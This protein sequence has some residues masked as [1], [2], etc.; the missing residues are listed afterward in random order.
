MID[1]TPDLETIL[2]KVQKLLNVEGRTP[3]EAAAYV[4]K[5]HAI[6]ADYDL[7][8]ESVHNLT[9]DKRTA[10]RKADSG[11][12]TVSGKPD[13]WKADILEAVAR[14][15][16]CKVIWAY[17]TEQTKSGNYR[18]VRVGNLI[19]FGHD[20][21]AAGYANSF[22][23]NEITRLAKAY[24]RPM[25]DQIKA[26][27]ARFGSSIHDA[28]KRY[29]DLWGRHPLKAELYF[30]RGAAETVKEALEEHARER[31]WAAVQNNPNALVVQKAA[32]VNDFLF[33]ER[34][35]GMSRA[36]YAARQDAW[37]Q[38]MGFDSFRAYEEHRSAEWR[39]EHEA[40]HPEKPETDAQRR[41]R[42]AR[43]ERAQE[44]ANRT[45]WNRIDRESRATD[46]DAVY[47]GREA[48]RTIRIRL[49][50]NPGDSKEGIG[51]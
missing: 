34:H 8:I 13:G 2:A 3:E 29:T 31:E 33:A 45:Y 24:S 14:S 19:G 11:T 4:E 42:E 44:R 6:L 25:W 20:V 40:A 48:G 10:V 41:K 22:L 51:A 27:A 36:E 30:I 16:E 43:E 32:E 49:G 39:R 37:A 15:F 47:A 5:A 50:V 12:R 23:V 17:E 1:K 21:E 38:G 7:T 26:D 18:S 9:A 28:E 35:D 46:H